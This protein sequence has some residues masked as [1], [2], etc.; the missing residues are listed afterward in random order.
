MVFYLSYIFVKYSLEFILTGDDDYK[1]F[2]CQVLWI[3]VL[4]VWVD[5]IL[6]VIDLLHILNDWYRYY[7]GYGYGGWWHFFKD[8]NIIIS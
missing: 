7:G 3:L 2:G 5:I 8:R 6:P 4:V 1:R